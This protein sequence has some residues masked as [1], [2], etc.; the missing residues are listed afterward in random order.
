MRNTNSGTDSAGHG[1]ASAVRN[2]GANVGGSVPNAGSANASA[3]SPSR[4]DTDSKLSW[5]EQKELQAKQRK[6]QNRIAALE[7]TIEQCEARIAE[8]DDLMASPEVCT[9]SLRLNELGKEREAEEETLLEAMT[10]WEELTSDP[11]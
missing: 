8:I 2:A 3:A 6:L 5:Q 1:N 4:K 11:G 10:E 9:N 7:K